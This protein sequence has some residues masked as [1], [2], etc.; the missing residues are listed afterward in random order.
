VYFDRERPLTPESAET[1]DSYAI[2]GP[3]VTA[4][5]GDSP[6]QAN[7]DPRENS[8][9]LTFKDYPDDGEYTITVKKKTSNQNHGVVDIYG[10]PLWS[11]KTPGETFTIIRSKLSGPSVRPG[12]SG[13][14][15][16]YVAYPEFTQPR[17]VPDGFN[18][19]DKVET[20]V[21]RLYYYRDAHRVAQIIN[22]EVKSYNRQ[23]VD[24]ARQLA[25][26]ARSDADRRTESRK[27]AERAAI[28]KAQETRR[29]ES[30][31]RVAEEGLNRSVQELTNARR[32]G[33]RPRM[34]S[35]SNWKLPP[36]RSP[37]NSIRSAAT[38]SGL[39]PM[40][41]KPTN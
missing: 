14:T 18:P 29:I 16:P 19:N 31:L 25:D 35:S 27:E 36:A 23:G 20:R 17:T 1:P 7:L 32:Q 21:V 22:R 15:G 9:T 30:Q 2:T 34:R 40:K 33:H 8:V 26:K 4:N 6:L 38:S 10:N 28:L 41:P 13:R 5:Q 12:I 11:D 3:S 39:E 24:M 37:I